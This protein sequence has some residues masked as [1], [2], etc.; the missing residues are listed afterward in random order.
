MRALFALA[1]GLLLAA[2]GCASL[3]VVPPPPEA[4]RFLQRPKSLLDRVRA[5]R[6]GFRDLR[7]LVEITLDSP[8]ERYAGKAVLVLQAEGSIRLEPLNFF[9]Q[10]VFYLVAHKDQLEAYAPREGNLFRGRATARNLHQWMGIPLSPREVV[11]ILWGGMPSLDAGAGLTAVWDGAV[12][13]AGSYRLDFLSGG[14]VARRSWVDPR[15]LLPL[16]FQAFDAR[17]GVLLTVRYEDYRRVS[18]VWLPEAVEVAVGPSERTLSLSY[19][20]V[21]VNG[22]LGPLAFHLPVPQGTPVI[23]IDP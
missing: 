14:R 17:G 18:G 10:P 20:R 2:A 1:A 5:R 22:G 12:G 9:G 15:T 21:A 19:G 13:K 11:N 4:A 7:G 23:P 16:R 3:G 8:R 6:N